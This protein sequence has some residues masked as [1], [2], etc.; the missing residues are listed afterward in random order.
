M[1]NYMKTEWSLTALKECEK[2]DIDGGYVEPNITQTGE[3]SNAEP[4]KEYIKIVTVLW[5]F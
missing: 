2:K 1:N 3:N 5:L 4:S